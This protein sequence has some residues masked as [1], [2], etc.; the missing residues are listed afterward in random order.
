MWHSVQIEVDGSLVGAAVR[1]Q[2]GVRFIATDVRVAELDQTLWPATADA[3]EARNRWSA[4]ATC[5]TSIHNPLKTKT[6]HRR[7]NG[8]L[9]TERASEA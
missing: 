1:Q 2:N 8:S 3:R 4:P 6:G 7:L 5:G 9:R